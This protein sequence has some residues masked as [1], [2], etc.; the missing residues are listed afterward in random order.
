MVLSLQDDEGWLVADLP[1]V[2]IVK[3]GHYVKAI[4]DDPA[5]VGAP[6]SS[7]GALY[8][9]NGMEATVA[10]L[11]GLKSPAVLAELE[12]ALA[13]C[14]LAGFVAEGMNPY[15]YMDES[16]I[17]AALLKSV[18]SGVPVAAESGVQGPA[19]ALVGATESGVERPA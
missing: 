10:A 16:G 18:L 2:G 13:E 4:R 11:K 17:D 7:R 3:T 6:F 19:V 5:A 15:A 14:A 8:G 1:R 12:A 9:G